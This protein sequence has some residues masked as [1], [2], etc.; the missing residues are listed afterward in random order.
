MVMSVGARGGGGAAATGA[1]AGAGAAGWAGSSGGVGTGVS[2][3][4][5][6]FESAPSGIAADEAFRPPRG[7]DM[8][9]P[10]RGRGRDGR[11]T[12]QGQINA[13]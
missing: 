12:N 10:F 8:A 5:F 3:M 1:A 2:D 6:S 9:R 13:C 11:E 4:T 7:L